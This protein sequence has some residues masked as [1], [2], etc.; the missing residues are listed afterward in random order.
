MR[1]TRPTLVMLHAASSTLA[2]LTVLTFLTAT[3]VVEIGGNPA[4]IALVKRA[5]VYGLAVLIPAMAVAGGTGSMLA[6][7]STAPL[8]RAKQRRMRIIGLNGLLVL[9]PCA[10]ALHLLAQTG[11]FGVAFYAVQSLEL[12]AGPVNLV[13]MGLNMRSGLRLSGRYRRASAS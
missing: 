12:V 11:S 2:F 13:L 8:I 5:I 1:P 7:R 6:G 4:A 9:V 10:V 3:V